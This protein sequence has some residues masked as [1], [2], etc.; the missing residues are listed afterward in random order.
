MLAAL[1]CCLGADGVGVWRGAEVGSMGVREYRSTGGSTGVQ[2][3]GSEGVR[4]Y[5]REGGSEGVRECVCVCV[6]FVNNDIYNIILYNNDI[7]IH[8]VIQD[9]SLHDLSQR[10]SRDPQL[11]VSQSLI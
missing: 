1:F 11:Q 8:T 10:V 2:E 5:G 7:V 3:Y 9:P 6:I 4:E